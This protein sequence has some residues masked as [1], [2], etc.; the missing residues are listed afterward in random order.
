MQGCVR[1]GS[2]VRRSKIMPLLYNDRSRDYFRHKAV[3]CQQVEDVGR[4]RRFT[5]VTLESWLATTRGGFARLHLDR[6][7]VVFRQPEPPHPSQCFF[8]APKTPNKGKGGTPSSKGKAKGGGGDGGD[9]VEEV[10]GDDVKA[11]K[12]KKA[13]RSPSAAAAAAA[14]GD[15]GGSSGVQPEAADLSKRDGGGGGDGGVGP[16]GGGTGVVTRPPPRVGKDGELVVQC[17]CGVAELEAQVN[18]AF[19]LVGWADQCC[20]TRHDAHRGLLSTVN[21]DVSSPFSGVLYFPCNTPLP[22]VPQRV[23]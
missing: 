1:V 6:C 21:V 5:S 18:F 8:S 23:S 19:R 14:A 4:G 9:N 22:Y 12:A 16:K 15:G 20:C 11:P 10:D 7:F 17:P 13:R 2:R 3:L